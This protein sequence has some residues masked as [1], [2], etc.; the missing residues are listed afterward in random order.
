[1]NWAGWEVPQPETFLTILTLLPQEYFC[2][3]N[4]RGEADSAS[5]YR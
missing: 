4:R 3:I 2:D 5:P 1:M